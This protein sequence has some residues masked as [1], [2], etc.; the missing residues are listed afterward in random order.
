VSAKGLWTKK[1]TKE[2][3][4]ICKEKGGKGEGG[5]VPDGGKYAGGNHIFRK[6]GG[7]KKEGE[8]WKKGKK[9]EP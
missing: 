1:G 5:R 7:E 6:S 9:G 8:R 4:I 3:S 2:H